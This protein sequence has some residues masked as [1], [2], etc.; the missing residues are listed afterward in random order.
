M[1]RAPLLTEADYQAFERSYISREIADQAGIYRVPSIEGRDLV[2]RKGGGDY[3]GIVFPYY[4]PGSRDLVLDRLRLDSPP[5][6]AATGK[7]EHKY[8]TAPGARNRL[9]F[10]PCDPALIGEVAIPLVITEGE[11]KCLSLWRAALESNGTGKPAFLP[12]AIAG[13]WCWRGSTGIRTNAKGERVPEKG[14]ISDFDRITWTGRKVTILFDANAATN[15]S[16]QAARK[17]LARELTRR[18][19]EVWVAKLPPAP[20]IN[21]IDDYFNLFGLTSGLEVLKQAIRYECRKE[22][23]RSDAGKV[24]PILA[25][26]IT[27]L[28][29]AP[30]WCGVL[31]WDEF[32]MRVVVLREAPWRSQ[33]EWT[34]QEDR[35]TTEWFQRTGIL[36]KLTEAGQAVQ[37]VAR[38]HAF[39]PVRQYLDGLRW[40]GM[41][42]CDTMLAC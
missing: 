9:Y 37:T 39:H 28:R 17:E 42:T 3:A 19:S 40:D 36:V 29:S 24:L 20:G 15:A 22:L 14:V 8:L 30:E 33:G 32:S 34:D 6:D 27:A 13:V 5:V 4:W 2:G 1:R 18:G 38:D 16:V 12:T 10:P 26:A 31:A 21:G 23:I 25:N 41:V 7:P 35:R 11:K